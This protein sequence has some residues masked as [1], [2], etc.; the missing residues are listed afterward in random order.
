VSKRGVLVGL[1]LLC[2]ALAVS[3]ALPERQGERAAEPRDVL[4]MASTIGPID[5]GIVGVLEDA[6]FARTRVLVR[7]AGA[8]TGAALEMTKRGGF[9]LVMVHA[10]ALEDKFI[11]DGFGVDRR[12]IMYNDFVIL[13]PAA[14][15]AKIRGEKRVVQALAKIAKAQALFVTRGD[16]SGTHVKEMELWAKA[17][18]KP[19]GSWYV[20]YEKG[21]DG[22]APTTRYANGRQA[23]VLMDRATILTLKKELGLQ[24]LVEKDPDLL[25]YIAVIRMNPAKFPKANAIGAKAFLD[26]LVSDEAQRLIKAFG[27]E[28]YG[29]S[30]FFPN[31]DEWRKKNPA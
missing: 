8:G 7:H 10:R 4:L 20:T 24:V 27:V 9:D 26:W 21:A 19:S 18:I 22:N 29:E 11:A 23:Y 30:L 13:G 3:C 14:D 16:R 2:L 12:D 5:A 31:S 25:N 17:G 28:T 6:Y 1:G 15:P